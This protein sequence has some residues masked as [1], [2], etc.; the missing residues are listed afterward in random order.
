MSDPEA[1]RN[2]PAAQTDDAAW[3]QR[4]LDAAPPGGSVLLDASR[5]SGAVIPNGSVPAGE[6][7]FQ[8][9]TQ[10]P[11][12]DQTQEFGEPVDEPDELVDP[13][14]DDWGFDEE[15]V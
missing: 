13:D 6:V 2:D 12:V 3:I 9:S 1:E 8:A 5:P 10:L 11:D 15:D 14:D 7:P 4:L